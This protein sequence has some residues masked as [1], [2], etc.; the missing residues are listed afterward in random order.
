[1]KTLFFILLAASFIG[2]WQKRTE[3]PRKVQSGIYSFYFIVFVA[4]VF[5]EGAP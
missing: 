2:F 1:M 4:A 5:G 3:Y